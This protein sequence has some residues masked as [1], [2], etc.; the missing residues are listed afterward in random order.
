M[1]S[2]DGNP[3]GPDNPL[4]LERAIAVA[5]WVK[6]TKVEW[7]NIPG[8][9]FIYRHN[10]TCTV[11]IVEANVQTLY[12]AIASHWLLKHPD[13][14]AVVLDALMW[15][16]PGDPPEDGLQRWQNGDRDNFATTL[17]LFHVD[18]QGRLSTIRLMYD[19]ICRIWERDVPDTTLENCEIPR[20][21]EQMFKCRQAEVN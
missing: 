16:G 20:W 14:F 10:I 6:E 4:T 13:E 12:R 2:L 21:L 3:I 15:T 5:R 8:A 17:A 11:D 1:T 19:P 9:C 7:N 18:G